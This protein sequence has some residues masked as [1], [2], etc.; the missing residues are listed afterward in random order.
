MRLQDV[1]FLAF[2]ALKDRRL[3]T[4]LT[5]LGIVIGTAMIVALIAS[6]TGLT[7]GVTA[8]I[9]KMGVTTLTVSPTGRTQLRDDDVQAVQRLEGVSEVIPFY[10]RRLQINYGST[11][12][13][14]RAYGVDTS[15]LF[16]LYR[17]LELDRGG[18]VDTYDPTG[19]IVGSSISRPPEMSLPSVDVNELLSVEQQST[20]RS[21]PPSYAFLVRGVLKPFG[22]VGF[23]NIDETV[24]LPLIGARLNFKQNYYSGMFVI[25]N[26]QDEVDLVQAGLQ[27]Y[28]GVNVR[29]NSAQSMLETVRTITSQLSFFMGGIAAV[30]LFV[31]GVGITNTMFVSI[32]ERTREIGVMKAIGYKARDILTMFLAEASM[33]G[34]VG[35]ILGTITGSLLSYLLSGGMPSFRMGPAAR[36][37]SAGFSPVISPDL[38]LFS[39]LFPIGISIVAGLYPAWRASRL[40]IVLALKYE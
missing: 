12:L 24:F 9:D 14:I 36:A 4:A 28:F 2:K 5:V 16:S 33:T 23:L 13:E 15:R 38:I 40:N 27:N 32:M 35:G 18:I 17:G 30:S 31:A 6:T 8:Q 3:K 26:S 39:L 37:S 22:V 20:G 1:F 21:R 11:I 10:S 19:V 29:I 7:A 25:A 34:I